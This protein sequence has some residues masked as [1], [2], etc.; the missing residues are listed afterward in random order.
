MDVEM[1]GV[2]VARVP[3]QC[4]LVPGD[5]NCDGRVNFGDIDPFVALITQ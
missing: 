2:G 4:E 3:D 5:A 1:R